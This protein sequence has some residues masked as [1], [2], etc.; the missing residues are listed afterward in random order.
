[1]LQINT[2]S[3]ETVAW[4]DEKPNN[5][6]SFNLAHSK[7]FISYSFA[8]KKG[9]LLSHS[10]PK[11]PAFNNHKV[12]IT[13]ATGEN[14]Y[15]QHLMCAT[16]SVSELNKLA[17]RLMITRPFIYESTIKNSS[18]TNYLADLAA[19]RADRVSSLFQTEE[20]DPS[21]TFKLRSIYK[22]GY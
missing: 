2:M 14:Y 13:I 22:N 11:Y 9:F 6:T 15:G 21:P 1:M 12:N 19:G 7:G 5:Q 4:N 20:F 8:D 10:L 3:M 17:Y 18:Q 16:M